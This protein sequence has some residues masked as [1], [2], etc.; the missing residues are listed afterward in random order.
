MHRLDV[1]IRDT[2]LCNL[3]SET[4]VV[5]VWN[6]KIERLFIFE[7]YLFDLFLFCYELFA[8]RG[9]VMMAGFIPRFWLFVDT[10]LRGL[11]YAN[12]K[13]QCQSVTMY[14]QRCSRLN[15]CP[16]QLILTFKL[17]IVKIGYFI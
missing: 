2:L 17:H 9:L 8:Y 14:F 3:C 4:V 15:K 5:V 13:G 11:S 16:P 1:H 12:V 6:G 10:R 7:V